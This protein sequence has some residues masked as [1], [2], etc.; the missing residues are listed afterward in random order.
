MNN[1][2]I[3]IEFLNGKAN[4]QKLGLNIQKN[5][6]FSY[7]EIIGLH[8]EDGSVTVYESKCG[9]FSKTTTRHIGIL[10]RAC[11]TLGVTQRTA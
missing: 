9:R 5:C 10:R 7:G 3:V 6:L 8:N 1:E 11:D 4:Y 2:K